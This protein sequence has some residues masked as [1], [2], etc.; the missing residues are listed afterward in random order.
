MLGGTSRDQDGLSLPTVAAMATN[1]RENRGEFLFLFGITVTAAYFLYATATLTRPD[2]AAVPWVILLIMVASLV[3]IYITLLFGDQLKQLLGTDSE[4][5]MNIDSTDPDDD[6]DDQV[7]FE[8]ELWGVT[9]EL[10]WIGAYVIG[11]VF[12]GFFTST[13]VFM[14][15]YI[16]LKEKSNIKRRLAYQAI[17][18]T[19]VLLILYVLFI[20]LLRVGAIFRLGFLP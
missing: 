2:S 10:V 11:I 18:T 13:I 3:L 12:V 14:N 1:F 17:W 20:E 4:D 7:M 9:K 19:G 5:W 6:D 15:A 16:F 8:I